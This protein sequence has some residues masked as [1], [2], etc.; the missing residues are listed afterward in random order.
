MRCGAK[1]TREQSQLL[2]QARAKPS[3]HSPLPCLKISYIIGELSKII[4]L[5]QLKAQKSIC[6]SNFS[7]RCNVIVGLLHRN[8]QPY[9]CTVYHTQSTTFLRGFFALGLLVGGD[10]LNCFLLV[11]QKL[12]PHQIYRSVSDHLKSFFK[13][14]SYITIKFPAAY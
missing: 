14:K 6:H 10:E 4:V 13:L 11:E 2:Q 1:N 5:D 9:Y 12:P 3:F 7:S 8:K